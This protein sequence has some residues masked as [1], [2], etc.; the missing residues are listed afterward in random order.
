MGVIGYVFPA[1][2]SF[3][4]LISGYSDLAEAYP[5]GELVDIFRQDWLT[6]FIKEAKSSREYQP[7][8][9]ETAR[10]ARELIK[11]QLGGQTG[12]IQQTTVGA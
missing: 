4:A 5:N 2:H 10:W 7:R 1:T 6:M 3:A 12:T 9:V 8:T 11:R